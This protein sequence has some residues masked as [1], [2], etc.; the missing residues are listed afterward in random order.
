M[1]TVQASMNGHDGDMDG[2][3]NYGTLSFLVLCLS[4]LRDGLDRMGRI[5]GRRF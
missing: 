5:E 3:F 1:V 2:S 4:L